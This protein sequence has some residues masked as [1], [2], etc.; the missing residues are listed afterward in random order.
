MNSSESGASSVDRILERIR[1]DASAEAETGDAS[2]GE[3]L[4]ALMDM[5]KMGWDAFRALE[6][7]ERPTLAPAADDDH[8]FAMIL[9]VSRQRAEALHH[10]VQV[11]LQ[12][13]G[14]LI[15]AAEPLLDLNGPVLPGMDLELVIDEAEQ[16]LGHLESCRL[17][18]F[19]V[20]RRHGEAMR[21]TTDLVANLAGAQSEAWSLVQ[22]LDAFVIDA[23]GADL[24]DIELTDPDL[25]ART[26]WDSGTHWRDSLTT[27]T[28]QHYSYEVRPG[29]FQ[30]QKGTERDSEV[31]VK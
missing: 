20:S 31:G 13:T 9:A 8:G 26:L 3:A 5:R 1:A 10:A 2:V 29:V 21:R 4:K 15:P 23:S 30:V 18:A 27:L 11:A 17:L 12:V 25:L 6:S 14:E 19:Q 16:L 24:S 22:R 7:V 28:I